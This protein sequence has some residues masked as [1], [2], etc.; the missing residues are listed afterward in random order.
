MIRYIR[1]FL[2]KD[3]DG[4]LNAEVKKNLVNEIML[5]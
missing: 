3:V 4:L 2:V 1:G 5:L